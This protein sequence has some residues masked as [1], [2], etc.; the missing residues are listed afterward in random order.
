MFIVWLWLE[1]IIIG[2]KKLIMYLCVLMCWV[3]INAFWFVVC[4]NL[5]C[6]CR[7]KCGCI[8]GPYYWKWILNRQFC[9]FHPLPTRPKGIPCPVPW[10][11]IP[12]VEL[13]YNLIIES[14]ANLSLDKFAKKSKTYFLRNAIYLNIEY[15]STFGQLRWWNSHT[16]RRWHSMIKRN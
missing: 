2:T 13:Q 9:D 1:L 11:L 3:N 12:G 7:L 10:L 8:L 16:G 6:A 15:C 4:L 5:W 14:P